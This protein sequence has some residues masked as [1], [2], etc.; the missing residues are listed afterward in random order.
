M[1]TSPHHV[2]RQLLRSP[3]AYVES[4]GKEDIAALGRAADAPDGKGT[5]LRLIL[6]ATANMPLRALSYVDCATR[7]ARL[8]PCEQVQ[9]IHANN[10]GNKVN[11]VDLELARKQAELLAAVSKLHIQA[12][13]PDVAAKV[14]HAEDTPVELEEITT[15]A[16]LALANSDIGFQLQK[17]GTKHGGDAVIYA[18]AHTKFQDTDHLVL[19]PLVSGPVQA[20]AERIISIGCQQER[21]FYAARIA[22]RPL[23]A[24]ETL[25]DTAQIFTRHLTP[26]YF[27]ALGGEQSLESALLH[28]VDLN[29]ARDLSTQRDLLHLHN[30]VQME[31]CNG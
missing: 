24:A 12:C 18:A 10:L 30:L 15:C 20:R 27:E 21:T 14:L 9:L 11:G 23:L 2:R 1:S 28:G 31:A 13:L 7:I 16:G 5:V 19:N 4:V 8:I 3:E 29:M 22:I 17:K 6:G 26:P 25:V